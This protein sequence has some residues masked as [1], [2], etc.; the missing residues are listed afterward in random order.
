MPLP[1]DVQPILFSLHTICDVTPETIAGPA[2]E[3]AIHLHEDDGRQI[4]FVAATVLPQIDHE[5]AEIESFKPFCSR[6]VRV[7]ALQIGTLVPSSPGPLGSS[8]KAKPRAL[9]P[10]GRESVTNRYSHP[11]LVVQFAAPS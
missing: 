4:E 3:N 11:L 1:K 5:R 6:D 7:Y 9:V 10:S 8:S 2:S